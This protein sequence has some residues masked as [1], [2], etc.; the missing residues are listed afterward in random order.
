MKEVT[1]LKFYVERLSGNSCSLRFSDKEISDE[2]AESR[3]RPSRKNF[4]DEEAEEEESSSRKNFGEEE[5]GN[6]NVKKTF[7][8]DDDSR[9]DADDK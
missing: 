7:D 8:D 6:K 9:V 3:D 1:Q 4:D 2:E 5:G